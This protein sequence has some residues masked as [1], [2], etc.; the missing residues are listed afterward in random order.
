MQELRECKQK[1]RGEQRE[2]EKFLDNINFYSKKK[3][4]GCSAKCSLSSEEERNGCL[5]ECYNRLDRRYKQYWSGQ[6]SN[7]EAKYQI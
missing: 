4:A 2:L 1:C 5:W 6:R 3:F 7:I